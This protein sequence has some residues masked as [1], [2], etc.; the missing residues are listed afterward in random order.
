MTWGHVLALTLAWSPLSGIR[1]LDRRV[2]VSVAIVQVTDDTHEQALLARIAWVESRM[3]PSARCKKGRGR[4]AWQVEARTRRDWLASCG[5]LDEQAAL[6]LE[7]VRESLGACAH[8]EPKD[9]LAVY[10]R[11]RCN[12]MRGRYLSRARWVD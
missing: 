9:R 7:R 3:T 11:G 12:D 8:L 10:A 5:P 4:G 1:D 6:A 2:A